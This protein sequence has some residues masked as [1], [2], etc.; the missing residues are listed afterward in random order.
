MP[1]E[2]LTSPVRGWH[3]D[4]VRSMPFVALLCIAL[5]ANFLFVSGYN[6]QRI[7]EIAVL[8][9]AG[10]LAVVRRRPA[11]QRL[12]PGAAGIFLAAFFV[13]G[14]LGSLTAFSSRF[15]VF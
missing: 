12:F 15:A 5:G 3:L 9:L 10:A 4:N 2:S 6:Q 7:L 1:T 14:L 13:L 8:C 11:L